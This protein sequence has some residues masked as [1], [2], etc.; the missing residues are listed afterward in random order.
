MPSGPVQGN[1]RHAGLQDL[2][3]QSRLPGS[4][5][6]LS[7]ATYQLGIG[8]MLRSLTSKEIWSL[9]SLISNSCLPSLFFSGHLE[10]SSLGMSESSRVSLWLH[11]SVLHNLAVL[12]DPLDLRYHG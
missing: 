11:S 1:R 7:G 2:P 5:S 4:Q 10:S 3:I 12:D 6:L 8:A 9:P